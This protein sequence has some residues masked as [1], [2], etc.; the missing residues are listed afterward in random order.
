M[1]TR[2][3]KNKCLQLLLQIQRS[4]PSHIKKL[5]S[6]PICDWKRSH[7][8]QGL[9]PE[10]KLTSRHL[11]FQH[12]LFTNWLKSTIL[13]LTP[14][15][16]KKKKLK[17]NNLGKLK[18]GC[19]KFQFI[20][21]QVM[22]KGEQQLWANTYFCRPSPEPNLRGNQKELVGEQMVTLP[23]AITV[24]KRARGRGGHG[25]T[26]SPY[27][28]CFLLQL[29]HVTDEKGQHLKVCVICHIRA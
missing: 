28:Q 10:R 16:K 17:K 12:V 21:S 8:V 20:G 6:K 7:E 2:L 22:G 11:L 27:M 25:L 24:L 4:L 19:A 29:W 3:M 18:R 14:P 9:R 15:Q 5:N 26:E 13:P 1:L 23:N